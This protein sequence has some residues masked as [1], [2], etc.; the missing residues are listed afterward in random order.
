MPAQHISLF[1]ATKNMDIL[2]KT[3]LFCLSIFIVAIQA[4]DSEITP[5]IQSNF[6]GAKLAVQGSISIDSV[7]L[8]LSQSVDPT[9]RVRNFDPYKVKNGSIYIESEDGGLRF[10]LNSN[11]GLTFKAYK[12]GL[13]SGKSYRVVAKADGFQSVNTNWILL[14]PAVAVQNLRCNQLSTS[15][16]KRNELS[17]GFEDS[18][19]KNFYFV[20]LG[21]KKGDRL[22]NAV[23]DIATRNSCFPDRIFNNS[24]FSGRSLNLSYNLRTEAQFEGGNETQLADSI[25]LRFGLISEELFRAYQTSNRNDGGLISGLN[26]PAPSFSNVIGGIGYVYALNLKDYV[27]PVC[28]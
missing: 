20:D 1:K 15:G 23:F 28:K 5:S 12:I 4:C 19:E 8:I 26:E 10:Q 18:G 3:K 17:F 25:Q 6:E 24:C 14:P 2:K 11:D 7:Y 21:I 27:I 13:K 16:V 9:T 22:T